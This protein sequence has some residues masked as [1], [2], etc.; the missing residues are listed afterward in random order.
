MR[1]AGRPPVQAWDFGAIALLAVA[2][3]VVAPHVAATDPGAWGP[4]ARVVR[5]LAIVA[6]AALVVAVV[7]RGTTWRQLGFVALPPRWPRHVAALTVLCVTPV[8]AAIAATLGHAGELV[9]NTQIRTLIPGDPDVAKVAALIF[10]AAVL[11]PLVEEPLFRGLLQGWLRRRVRARAAVPLAAL[12]FAVAHGVPAIMPWLFVVGVIL[13]T[14]YERA[15]CLWVP[16]LVHGLY[17]AVVAGA[18]ALAVAA[19]RLTLG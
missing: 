17:N 9:P 2:G 10:V 4:I 18:L 6:L 1:G 13:G 3:H 14:G 16:I 8:A 5:S 12:I 7:W 11:T 19:G 15:E